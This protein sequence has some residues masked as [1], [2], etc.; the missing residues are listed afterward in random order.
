MQAVDFKHV[1]G[2]KHGAQGAVPSGAVPVGIVLELQQVA[3]AVAQPLFT[4]STGMPVLN[5]VQMASP[6]QTAY[7]GW[8]GIKSCDPCLQGDINQLMLF[9]NTH[10]SRPL[11]GVRVHGWHRERRSRQRRVEDGDGKHHCVPL[12]TSHPRSTRRLHAQPR[13]CVSHVRTSAPCASMRSRAPLRLSCATARTVDETEH[14]WVTVDDFDYKID[15]SSFI[16][17]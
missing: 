17:P 14:Y 10:N 3:T 12:R 8:S 2:F 16:F 7:D 15:I 13:L 11:L 1:A 9:F 5:T 6:A 4:T